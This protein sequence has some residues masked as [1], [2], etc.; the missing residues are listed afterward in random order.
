MR[1]AQSRL[2]VGEAV[3]VFLASSNLTDRSRQGYRA[4]LDAL[5]A[6]FPQTPLATFESPEGMA[7][8][9]EWL[10]GRWGSLA[11]RT[12]NKSVS[13]IREFFRWHAGRGDLP[14]DLADRLQRRPVERKSRNVI[15]GEERDA[16]ALRVKPAPTTLGTT[17]IAPVELTTYRIRARLVEFKLEADSDVHLVI[18]DPA[19]GATM[20]A[21]LPAASC[22]GS[23]I[24]SVRKKITTARTA[25]ITACGT[26]SSSHFTHVTG[27]ATITGVGFWDFKHG[28]AGVAPNA[29]ELQP[30]MEFSGGCN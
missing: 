11:A 9:L 25:L 18:A 22:L 14:S 5:A 28:Q 13:V 7:L 26:P 15:T 27:M 4:V 23:T 12:Y 1:V 3:E 8:L 30:V 6:A 17:R 24:A 19:T 2:Q 29:I 21:E 16:T 20:I 10:D